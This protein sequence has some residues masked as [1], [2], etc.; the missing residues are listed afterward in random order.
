MCVF[1]YEANIGT[2]NVI[3]NV[4]L[5]FLDFVNAS[6]AVAHTLSFSI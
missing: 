5:F 4:M 6:L 3:A 2:F 1:S